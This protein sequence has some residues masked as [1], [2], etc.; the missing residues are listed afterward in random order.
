[1]TRPAY[2]ELE[3]PS[4]SDAVRYFSNVDA[5]VFSAV[6]NRCIAADTPCQPAMSMENVKK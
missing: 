1:L 4:E 5:G 3:R 2:R 6:V